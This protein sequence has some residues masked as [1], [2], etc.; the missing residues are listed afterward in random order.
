MCACSC[1]SPGTC[2]ELGVGWGLGF[3]PGGCPACSTHS[4][5]PVGSLGPR[6]ELDRLCEERLVQC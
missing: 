1:A 5:A 2:M 4:C 6:A 3:R